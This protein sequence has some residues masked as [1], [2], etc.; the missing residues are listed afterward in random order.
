[1]SENITENAI[2]KSVSISNG[3]HGC[4]SAWLH[5]EYD[6]GGQ[7]FG[8]YAL[9]TPDRTDNHNEQFPAAGHFIWRCLEIAGV[10]EWDKIPGK[11]IRVKHG[12]WGSTIEAIGHII[13]EDWFDP[14]VDFEKM[15]QDKKAQ[16]KASE[17]AS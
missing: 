9:F 10:T 16:K 13:K 5:L 3:D 1:M 6:S 17:L 12:G 8:G 2:I 7:G 4:L 15:R 14:K 11:T